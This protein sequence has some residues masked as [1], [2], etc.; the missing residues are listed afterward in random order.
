MV[1][2]LRHYVEAVITFS[3]PDRH[4]LAYKKY[5]LLSEILPTEANALN[6][7]HV[8]CIHFGAVYHT[9]GQG[10]PGHQLPCFNTLIHIKQINC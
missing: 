6:L 7:V 8:A 2:S 9:D 5:C 4:I 10:L 1:E 3:N